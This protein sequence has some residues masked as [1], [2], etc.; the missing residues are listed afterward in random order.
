MK[1]QSP[2]RIIWTQFLEEYEEY[3]KSDKEKWNEKMQELKMF[4]N[5]NKKRP[6]TISKITN[7]C[8]I[9]RWCNHQSSN[10]KKKSDSMKDPEIYSQWTQLLEEYKQYFDNTEESEEEIVIPPKPKKS[11]KLKEPSAKKETP[12][13]RKKRIRT[14]SELSALLKTYKKLTSQNMQKIFQESPELW[15]HFHDV[16]GESEKSFPEEFIPRNRIIQELT[17]IKGKRTR[18][19]VDMG[20]G[21]AQIADHFTND[22]R[23]T[24]INYD[25][26]SSKKNVLVQDISNTGL[27]D[28][29]VEI[30]ILCLAMWGSNCHDYVR[31]AYR[32]LESDGKLYIMEAT[33]RWTSEATESEA[34]ESEATE[35]KAEH[36]EPGG[37]L[38]KLLED[39]GFKIVKSSVEK[40][41]LFVCTK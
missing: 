20:C 41:S 34:T 25:H 15:Y 31:E 38:K 14:E 28:H 24:F 22:G 30:C 32:I 8:I 36:G 5:I 3:F 27:E 4:I 23:F 17:E 37:K 18:S 40:F 2:R 10:Y 29:S 9:G 26:V 16:S 21:K 1:E 6:S 19:V 13:Q 39:T 33:K 12:E 7:E 11:M 35:I